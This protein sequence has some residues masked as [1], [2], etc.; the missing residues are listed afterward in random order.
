MYEFFPSTRQ[1][2]KGKINRVKLATPDA[3]E[4]LPL[5]FVEGM[6]VRHGF[7]KI[8]PYYMSYDDCVSKYNEARQQALRRGADMSQ[9]PEEPPVQ[10]DNFRNVALAIDTG[11]V[12]Y[13][14]VPDS[15]QLEFIRRNIGKDQLARIYP[16]SQ[17]ER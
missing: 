2:V 17:E 15:K 1:Y 5:Y 6:Q 9:W 4:S 14:I 8:L 11:S 3:F 7:R 10:A 12:D 16:V 13:S